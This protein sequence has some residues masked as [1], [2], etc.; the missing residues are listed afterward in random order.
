MLW[1]TGHT[2]AALNS[3]L[4]DEVR[5]M[6][7]D[8]AGQML[9]DVS[10]IASGH[11]GVLHWVDSMVQHLALE[12]RVPL[13]PAFEILYPQ[14]EIED[15]QAVTERQTNDVLEL[16]RSWAS[17]SPDH[18]V[19]TIIEMENEALL[20]GISWPRWTPLLCEEIATTASNPC[21]WAQ[22]LIQHQ[23][24]P[25]LVQP[26]LRVSAA[27]NESEWSGLIKA[28]LLDSRFRP[29]AIS[30]LL[31]MSD[32]PSGLLSIVLSSLEGYSQMIDV[33]C[34]RAQVPLETLRLLLQHEDATIAGAAALGAWH[35]RDRVP[36]IESLRND[37]CKA[38][39]RTAI[40]DYWL[41]QV[42]GHEPELAH[43][44]LQ[45]RLAEDFR[46]SY[47]HDSALKAAIAALNLEQ[48]SRI[49]ADLPAQFG[50]EEVVLQLVGDNLDLYQQLLENQ[51]LKRFHLIPL[52][53]HPEEIWIS[54]ARLALDAGYCPDDIAHA[55]VWANP[56]GFCFREAKQPC[57]LNG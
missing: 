29:A 22:A 52:A 30:V 32:P 14:R 44:W 36:I 54:K 10:G 24:S 17:D 50:F 43:D 38:I 35:A 45:A 11:P 5:L 1:R 20:A 53:G 39:T 13:E 18:A 56:A 55:A 42:L 15:W 34:L 27:K 7:K 51:R 37:W 12:I 31:T 25:D 21:A 40:D 3:H 4:P 19:S 47:R 33:L 23:A 9:R 16:A 6:M 49:L 26:F 28:C 8:F 46:Q 41:A 57:G 2:Q 48:K